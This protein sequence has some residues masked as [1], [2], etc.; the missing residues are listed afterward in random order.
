MGKDVNLEAR[1]AI[2]ATESENVPTGKR[3]AFTF[4]EG[5]DKDMRKIQNCARTLAE[6]NDISLAIIG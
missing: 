6:Y 3:P 1:A 2:A 4:S 5:G